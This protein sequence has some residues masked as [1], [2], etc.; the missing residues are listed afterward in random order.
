M[1]GVL[2]QEGHVVCYEYRKLKE[3]E[4]NYAAHDIELAAVVHALKMWR[5][6]LLGKMFLLLTNNTRVKTMFTQLGLN[7]RK[8]IWIAFLSEFD[9]DVQHIKG[10]ENRV[11]DALS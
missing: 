9:F 8:E 7:V 1:G 3:H 5:H 10:K 2:S 11:A 6:Y 4:Q